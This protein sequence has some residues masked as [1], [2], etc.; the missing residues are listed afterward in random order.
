ML[1]ATQDQT[2]QLSTADVEAAAARIASRIVCTPCLRSPALSEL[3]GAEIFVKYENLQ[4]THS[5]KERGALN[6]LL[7]LDVNERRRGV[8]TMSAGNHGQAVAC[9]AGGSRSPRPSSCRCI[10]PT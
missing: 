7:Q 6:F 8:V 1:T 9:H 3:T 5:F 10:R 2:G 4:F